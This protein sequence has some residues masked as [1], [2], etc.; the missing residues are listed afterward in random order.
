MYRG[1]PYLKSTVE[2]ARPSAK[3]TLAR[4]KMTFAR[5]IQLESNIFIESAEG[6]SAIF[7]RIKNAFRVDFQTLSFAL[8]QVSSQTRLA[9]TKRLLHM[10]PFLRL[11]C[12]PASL[13]YNF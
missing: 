13:I 12:T 10:R 4:G 8:V 7:I 9:P 2:Q 6:A 3:T 1:A 5:D 11:R